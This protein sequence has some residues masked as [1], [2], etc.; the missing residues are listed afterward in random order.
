VAAAEPTF[1][2][3][4]ASCEQSA[5]HLEM[6]DGYSTTDPAFLAW[7]TN[8]AIDPL[9]W[10]GSWLPLVGGAVARGVVVR[11]ARVVSEPISDY[12]RFEH[13]IT[14]AL[15]LAAGEDVRWLPRHSATT[16]CLPGNDFWLFDDQAVMVNHFSGSGES[17]GH[18]VRHDRELVYLCATSFAAVWDLAVPHK[19]YHPA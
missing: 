10:Y 3:L 13:D 12:V 6:R 1:E 14:T 11:R 8:R 2:E 5:V 17:S 15:N 18:E 4:L 16:L 9:Y 19:E 7:Q